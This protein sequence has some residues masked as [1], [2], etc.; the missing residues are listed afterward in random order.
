MVR[1]QNPVLVHE[2]HL[3]VWYTLL[4]RGQL[5]DVIVLVVFL[6]VPLERD[7]LSPPPEETIVLAVSGNLGSATS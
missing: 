7:G 2:R 6:S 3:Q 1:R 4:N 5:S